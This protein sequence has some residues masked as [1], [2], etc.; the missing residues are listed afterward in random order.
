MIKRRQVFYFATMGACTICTIS[1]RSMFFF[2]NE[3]VPLHLLAFAVNYH[4]IFQNSTAST[5]RRKKLFY[6]N[7]ITSVLYNLKGLE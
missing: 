4:A 1:K 6:Y 7:K 3:V 5:K 2:E